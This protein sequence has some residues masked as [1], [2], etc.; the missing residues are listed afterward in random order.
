MFLKNFRSYTG[1]IIRSFRLQSL[2]EHRDFCWRTFTGT[3][4]WTFTGS[5]FTESPFFEA[6]QQKCL[7]KVKNLAVYWALEWA[8]FSAIRQYFRQHF[9]LYFQLYFR[10]YRLNTSE[11]CRTGSSN[12]VI[13]IAELR[14]DRFRQRSI[15]SIR[16][17]KGNLLAIQSGAAQEAQIIRP[18]NS[19]IWPARNGE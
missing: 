16:Q 15:C 2:V 10:L 5:P 8:A 19:I 12:S 17:F 6:L 13:L 1:E 18:P 4:T 9:R 7:I 14:I 3:F 11:E